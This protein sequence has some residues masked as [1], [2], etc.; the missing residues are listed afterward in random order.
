M[1]TKQTI[2]ERFRCSYSTKSTLSQR[3]NARWAPARRWINV[4]YPMGYSIY[5]N[6]RGMPSYG[7]RMN[8]CRSLCIFNVG[9]TLNQRRVNMLSRQRRPNVDSM[10]CVLH[11]ILNTSNRHTLES[12]KQYIL[13]IMQSKYYFE[14]FRCSRNIVDSSLIKRSVQMRHTIYNNLNF[15]W[16]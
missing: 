4:K 14:C 10:S 5:N 2:L 12:N 3:K 7:I 6:N 1:K 16:L 13:N 8:I 15:T 9:S 11:G